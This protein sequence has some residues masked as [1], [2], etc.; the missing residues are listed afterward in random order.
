[1]VNGL[2]LYRIIF[3]RIILMLVVGSLRAAKPSGSGHCKEITSVQTAPRVPNEYCLLSWFS[4]SKPMFNPFS[5]LL[6]SLQPPHEQVAHLTGKNC[7]LNS[8]AVS[9]LL[10]S[11]EQVSI[12]DYTKKSK[13][14]PVHA[15][16]PL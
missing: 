15:I 6:R 10:D 7:S 3:I 2:H 14:V 8:Y 9:A 5:S 13:Y 11:G 16:Q 12:I 4:G 1:M